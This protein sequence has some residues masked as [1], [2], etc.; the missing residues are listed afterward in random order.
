VVLDD[1]VA[2]ARA[3]GL[4]YSSDVQPGIQRIACGK[5]FRYRHPGGKAVSSDDRARIRSLAIPPAYR[6]VWICR[7]ADGHLQATGRDARGRKQYRYHAEWSKIRGE[8][9][10]ERM[11]EFA[12]ALPSIRERVDGDLSSKGISRNR[13]LATIVYL[14]EN[15]LIRVGNDEYAKQNGSYGLTTLKNRHVELSGDTV[16]FRFRGKSG[17]ERDLSIRD[18]RVAKVVRSCQELPGQRLFEYIDE[19][20]EVASIDSADV[21]AYIREITS[22]RFSTK[23]FRTWAAT[24]LCGAILR[25][26]GRSDDDK[27]AKRRVKEAIAHVARRLGNTAAVCRASYVHPEI[28]DAYT[29]GALFRSRMRGTTSLQA[30][31]AAALRAIGA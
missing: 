13:V 8:T 25:K 23:D 24:V 6:D 29:S 12:R 28:I 4:H 11:V 19:N 18:R 1:G 2:S 7:D 14:L 27:T 31:E 22:D 20:G 10:F 15:A 16:R 21:N 30:A 9:K 26:A 3:A 5:G 17:V